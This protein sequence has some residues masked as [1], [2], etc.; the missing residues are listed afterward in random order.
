MK[1]YMEKY[2]T[3]FL[4][5]QILARPDDSGRAVLFPMQQKLLASGAYQCAMI[6]ARIGLIFKCFCLNDIFLCL[7]AKFAK[8]L[9]KSL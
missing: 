6:L 2:L 9:T 3:D 5:N 4:N 7:N 1:N 8:K